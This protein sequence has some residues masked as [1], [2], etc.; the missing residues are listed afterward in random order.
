ATDHSLEFADRVFML[1]PGV[2]EAESQQIIAGNP[3][4][5]EAV[6]DASPPAFWLTPAFRPGTPLQF[7]DTVFAFLP[8][9]TE[10][11]SQQIV[12]ANPTL[13][14][15]VPNAPPVPNTTTPSLQLSAAFG[16]DTAINIP[17]GISLSSADANA[18][19][20]KYSTDAADAGTFLLNYHA[21]KVI[22]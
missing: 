14:I 16:P 11:Q 12:A 2:I 21:I 13:F 8:G 9:V 15:P 17:D 5:F 6:P 1:L 7:T 18:A 3:A 19:M 20:V 10:L 22:P 4:V